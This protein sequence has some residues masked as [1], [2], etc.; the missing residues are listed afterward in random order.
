MDPRALDAEQHSQVDGGPARSRLA[1]VAAQL[2]AWKALNPLEETLPTSPQSLIGPLP[3]L[4]R[5]ARRVDAAGGG[6]GC[7][8]QAL[9][10]IQGQRLK[11]SSLKEMSN[12]NNCTQTSPPPQYNSCLRCLCKQRQC[13]PGPPGSK[14]VAASPTQPAACSFCR[15]QQRNFSSGCP[16]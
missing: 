4:P 12:S 3:P 9:G 10:C 7:P 16:F 5:L 6:R 8:V 15:I 2:I 14:P 11:V 13:L 1:T